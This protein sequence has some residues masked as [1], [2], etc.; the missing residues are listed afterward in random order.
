VVWCGWLFEL[1]VV[2]KCGVVLKGDWMF[3]LGV[4]LKCGVVLCGV[5][6]CL[7]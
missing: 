1:G 5:A 6:G 7:I 3:E 2:L 4:V